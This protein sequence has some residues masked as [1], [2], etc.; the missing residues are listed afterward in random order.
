MAA[1]GSGFPARCGSLAEQ[2]GLSM[3]EAHRALH[4]L[5]DRK[6]LRLVEDRLEVAD[7]EA[8]AGCLDRSG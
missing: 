4:Q 8:L 2:A 6:L 1:W 7:L 3:F 5:F